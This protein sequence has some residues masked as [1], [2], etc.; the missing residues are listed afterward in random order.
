[1]LGEIVGYGATTD[2]HHITSPDFQGAAR[3]MQLA[4]ERAGIAPTEIDYI[5]AHGTSTPDGDT[6]ETKAIK[7]LFGNHADHLLVSSTKSMTGHLFGAAGGVEAIITLKSMMDG[8]APPTINYERVDEQCDLNYV[9]NEAV[10]INMNYALS[11]GFGFGGHNAVL[12]FK[13]VD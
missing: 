7:H 12:A 2:A 4:I 3:A 10:A 5:N 9:P 6:S 13:K 11:N 1:I 8:I